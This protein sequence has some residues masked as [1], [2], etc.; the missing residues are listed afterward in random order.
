MKGKWVLRAPGLFRLTW[1]LICVA[2]LQLSLTLVSLEVLSSL[3]AYGN[4][5]SMW[6]KGQKDAVYFLVLYTESHNEEHYQRYLDAIAL[7]LGDYRGRLAMEA[8]QFSYD[9]AYAGLRAGGNSPEDIERVIWLFRHFHN[10]GPFPRIIRIWAETDAPLLELRQLGEKIHHALHGTAREEWSDHDDWKARIY[11]IND[12]ITPL[13]LAFSEAVVKTAHDLTRGL[14]AANFAACLVMI[15]FGLMATRKLVG[16]REK[17]E[18]ELRDE[19]QRAQ[20]TLAALGDAVLAVDE[21]C[22]VTYMNPAAERLA[23]QQA[24]N[25]RLRPLADL[26]GLLDEHG[27]DDG[28]HPVEEIL[29][30]KMD[31]AVSASRQLRRQDGT[32]IMVSMV[33]APVHLH[34]GAAGAVVVLHDTTRERQYVANL[35]WQASHDALTGLV[36]RR[37]FDRRLT[38]AVGRQ[39]E[40]SA[41]HVLMYLDFDQFKIINDTCGHAVGDQLICQAARQLQAC[42]RESDTLARLG[43]DEFGVLLENCPVEPAMKIAE[44]LRKAVQDLDFSSNGRTFSIGVSI[45]LVGLAPSQFEVAEALKAAD[46]ACYLAKEKGRN[47]IQVYNAEDSDLS[48][49][50]GEM[51]WVQ[52]IHQALEEQRFCL[53]SQ[54]IAS[55]S[56]AGGEGAHIEIL[57]RLRDENGNLVSPGE[58]I[59]AAE[60]YG[61]MPLLDRWVVENALKILAERYQGADRPI[62]ICAINLSGLTVGDQE[63]LAFLREQIGRYRLPPGMICFEVTETTAI[64]NLSHAIRFI[65]ELQALGCRFAL[66]DFGAG[67]SSFAYLKQLP[68]D[69]L[70]I[71]GSFVRDMLENPVD[72]AMVEMISRL[73]RL[74]GKQ[75][76]AEFVESRG[77]FSALEEIGVNYAQGYAIARPAPFFVPDCV[78]RAVTRES[79]SSGDP[80]FLP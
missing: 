2:V 63:F 65:R 29:K 67:M 36:N 79:A 54:D 27:Q 20:I 48:M 25:A 13:A 31:S 42:L 9:D 71:D 56:P 5:E 46:M 43:G 69:Y 78:G 28:L 58:F 41:H 49:R 59:P 1:P 62:A 70:K 66:D 52:K 21:Q 37:E 4:G 22:R 40:S 45:G 11:A 50:F 17:A 76:I 3:H 53:Y 19:Q 6:S 32:E 74:M 72:Y 47:R 14:V 60:R 68:V 73:G 24:G 30:G 39:Q 26:F 18:E 10:I 61:L 23:Q 12:R 33:V 35:S 34:E 80:A 8:E 38:R 75:T 64:A 44:N 51:E 7:P 16:Q 55:V 57:L 15:V 77:I